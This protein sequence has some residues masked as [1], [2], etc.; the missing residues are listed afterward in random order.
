M[1]VDYF[2]TLI[3]QLYG[4]IVF[5]YFILIG[6][7]GFNATICFHDFLVAVGQ[8]LKFSFACNDFPI[9]VST[10]NF[11]L[12]GQTAIFSPCISFFIKYK[13]DASVYLKNYTLT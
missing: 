10:S 8:L 1:I 3:Q 9:F 2:I 12:N 5:A 7:N 6:L 4:N 13:K 11:V